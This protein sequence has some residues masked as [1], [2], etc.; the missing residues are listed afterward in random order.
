MTIEFSCGG[1][2]YPFKVPDSMA[3][4]QGKCP[5]CGTITA[6]PTS[7]SASRVV[8]RNRP[9]VARLRP[10]Q[11]HR[12]RRLRRSPLQRAAKKKSGKGM[13]IGLT[14]AALVLL[15][16]GGWAVYYFFFASS[17]LSSEDA[18]FMPAGS[19]VIMSAKVEEFLTSSMWKDL[20]KKYSELE[21]GESNATKE[22]PISLTDIERVVVGVDPDKEEFIAVAHMKK[23]TKAADYESKVPGQIKFKDTKVGKYTMR[24][25]ESES[26]PIAYCQVDTK[27][28][29]WSVMPKSLKT[30][31]ERDKKPDFSPV[32]ENV[33]KETDFGKTFAMAV[34]M[35][36]LD[37]G[38]RQKRSVGAH[39]WASTFLG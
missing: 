33:L 4:K 2:Q 25:S 29:S 11:R 24:E 38:Q 12:A 34:N 15:G 7:S 10:N 22:L 28:S 18:K 16:G 39:F 13:A 27:L 36:E 20:K 1:C 9:P 26:N 32:M 17:G 21:K 3:G 6:I 35:K 30:A 14:I 5:K 37:A 31:L 8:G 19:K 23:A